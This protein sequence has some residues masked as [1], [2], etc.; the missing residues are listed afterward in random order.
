MDNITIKF[1]NPYWASM[2]WHGELPTK[3]REHARMLRVFASDEDLDK[4]EGIAMTIFYVS[5]WLATA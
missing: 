2:I 4:Q 5:M 3:A 1:S